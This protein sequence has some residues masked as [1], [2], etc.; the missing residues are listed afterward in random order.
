[1]SEQI[2]D[3]DNLRLAVAFDPNSSCGAQTLAQTRGAAQTR[4]QILTQQPKFFRKYL[5]GFLFLN[6]FG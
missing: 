6:N 4:L 1:M 3:S 5:V 2:L